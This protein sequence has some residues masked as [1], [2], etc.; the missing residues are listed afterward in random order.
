MPRKT[1]GQRA[2]WHRVR[3]PAR[4]PEARASA[5]DAVVIVKGV[6]EGDKPGAGTPASTARLVRESQ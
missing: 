1:G 5:A 3:R 4:K 2:A 6:R